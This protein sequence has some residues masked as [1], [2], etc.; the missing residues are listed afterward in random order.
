LYNKQI[1]E[2]GM[3][4]PGALF[5]NFEKSQKVLQEIGNFYHFGKKYIKADKVI[6]NWVSYLNVIEFHN[7]G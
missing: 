3:S 6:R 4:S 1:S 2:L 7:E 5:N